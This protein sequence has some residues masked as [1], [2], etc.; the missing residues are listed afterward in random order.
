MEHESTTPCMKKPT[1]S[2][3]NCCVIMEKITYLIK[4]LVMLVN[5]VNIYLFNYIFNG[6]SYIRGCYS[7][8]IFRWCIHYYFFFF[9]LFF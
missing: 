8:R 3:I 1:K 4:I 2:Y 5:K 6:H 9:F 7:W